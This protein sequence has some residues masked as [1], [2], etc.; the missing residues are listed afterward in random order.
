MTNHRP[1]CES[2]VTFYK[3]YSHTALQPLHLVHHRSQIC[4]H[5]AWHY[6]SANICVLSA[7]VINTMFLWHQ[8]EL[9]SSAVLLLAPYF[10][11]NI[12]LALPP[13]WQRHPMV[14][15]LLASGII[16]LLVAANHLAFFLPFIID[17]GKESLFIGK[18]HL[19][20]SFYMTL[21]TRV[22]GPWL[23]CEVEGNLQPTVMAH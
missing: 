21:I 12:Y 22:K 7:L 2:K 11:E 19:K 23:R 20:T 18:V 5:T 4:S 14:W 6:R 13:G 8:R 9:Q 10:T 1:Q 3:I 17:T 15:V 16:Y